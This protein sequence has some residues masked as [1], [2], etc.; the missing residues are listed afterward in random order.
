M[1]R[2]NVVKLALQLEQEVQAFELEKERR[3][4][5]AELSKNM[6]STDDFKSLAEYYFFFIKYKAFS[7]T[8]Q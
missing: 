5:A 2:P 6:D 8:L 1:E 3:R 7:I 4:S